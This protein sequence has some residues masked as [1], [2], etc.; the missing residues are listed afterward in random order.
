[1]KTTAKFGI[2]GVMATVL[3]AGVVAQ[4]PSNSTSKSG[5][6]SAASAA[7]TDT[8]TQKATKVSLYRPLEIAHIRPAD[9]RGVNV[10]ESPKDDVVPFTGFALSFG[11]AFNQ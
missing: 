6:T 10:F 11:G 7:S 8:T 2:A 5:S 1:M 3:A 4:Q 9:K